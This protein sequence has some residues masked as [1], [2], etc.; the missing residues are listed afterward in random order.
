M[1]YL[2]FT[3]CNRPGSVFRFSRVRTPSNKFFFADTYNSKPYSENTGRDSFNMNGSAGCV[4]PRHMLNVNILHAD[5]HVAA[6]RA[7]DKD[8]PHSAYPFKH[9]DPNSIKYLSPSG[10]YSTL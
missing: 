7:N 2:F 5:M 8:D 4:A 1:S 9:D 10:D 3:N 6:V